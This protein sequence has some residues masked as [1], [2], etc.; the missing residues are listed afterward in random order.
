VRIEAGDVASS[1]AAPSTLETIVA[2][3]SIPSGSMLPTL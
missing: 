2:P 1:S 3:F